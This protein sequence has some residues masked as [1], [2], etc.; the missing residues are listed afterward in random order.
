MQ[1]KTSNQQEHIF[2]NCENGDNS[3]TQQIDTFQPPASL[4]NSAVG[5]RA[6]GPT[7]TQGRNIRKEMRF[8]NNQTDQLPKHLFNR[9]INENEMMKQST[10]LKM[11]S[12]S[13]SAGPDM[14]KSSINTNAHNVQMLMTEIDDKLNNGDK[15]QENYENDWEDVEE[16]VIVVDYTKINDLISKE[17]VKNMSHNQGDL[18]IDKLN[19]RLHQEDRA[20][21]MQEMV[22]FKMDRQQK[23]TW[24]QG[25]FYPVVGTTLVLEIDTVLQD[26]K[27]LGK[28]QEYFLLDRKHLGSYAKINKANVLENMLDQV[29]LNQNRVGVNGLKVLR[30]PTLNSGKSSKR[31]HVQRK[32]DGVKNMLDDE[33]CDDD[34][35]LDVDNDGGSRR[36]RDKKKWKQH[37]KISIQVLDSAQLAELKA[38][39]VKH[40]DSDDNDADNNSQQEEQKLDNH[41]HQDELKDESGA[42][43]QYEQNF[44]QKRQVSFRDKYLKENLGNEQR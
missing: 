16:Q 23:L 19:N 32:A 11:P 22:G 17:G 8:S 1:E 6:D 21:T 31:R 25:Q 24:Y 13:R 38:S 37:S 20:K 14:I 43:Q 33:F 7:M 34:A 5:W 3:I 28:S 42:Y 26:T 36:K 41:Q 39:K 15:H 10:V 44:N 29:A 2:Q 30:N 40:E 18:S 27:I 4:F 9:K 12:P 35:E